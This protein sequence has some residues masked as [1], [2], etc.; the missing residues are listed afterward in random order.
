MS[1]NDASVKK[2]ITVLCIIAGVILIS[3]IAVVF[4]RSRFSAPVSGTKTALIY[5]DGELIKKIDLNLSEDTSFLVEAKDGGSNLIQ[6]KDHDICV[7][8]ATCPNGLCI[9]QGYAGKIHIPVVCLPNKLVIIVENN[10]GGK[11][12]EYDTITY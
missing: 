1:T 2:R 10:A 8:E 12:G 11:E 9:K 5:S 6:I 4:I 3:S 7:A